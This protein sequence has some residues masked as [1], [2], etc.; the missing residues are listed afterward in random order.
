[1]NSI[2]FFFMHIVF[3]TSLVGIHRANFADFILGLRN[4]HSQSHLY[5]G[6]RVVW[7]VC[8]AVEKNAGM[9]EN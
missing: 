3:K 2:G 7:K 5:N 4:C 6:F 1:M 9:P 8:M